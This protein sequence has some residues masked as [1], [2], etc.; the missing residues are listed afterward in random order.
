[1]FELN[2]LQNKISSFFGSNRSIKK[3]DP[4]GDSLDDQDQ[5]N[6]NEE[7]LA[8]EITAL[9]DDGTITP[10]TE[11]VHK[12]AVSK[13][14]SEEAAEDFANTVIS[15]YFSDNEEDYEDMAKE[16]LEDLEDYE[17]EE[18]DEDEEIDEDEEELDE[19]EKSALA[20]LRKLN[21]TNKMVLKGMA[22]M[23]DAL[24][25]ALDKIQKFEGE[26]S[27]LKEEISFM[28]SKMG[29]L[30]FTPANSKA[31]V[32][33]VQTSRNFAEP[34]ISI[35]VIKSWVKEKFLQGNQY[36][37]TTQEVAALDQGFISNN[38]KNN[39]LKERG[40]K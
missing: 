2:K 30:K 9:L 32:T 1:M 26:N 21:E 17:D 14:L 25:L 7:I 15:A 16:D 40:I 38:I 27:S 29:E 12:W 37:F 13:G 11:K 18:M 4:L 3:S 20:E 19:I 5:G 39:Y 22:T 31:P 28:K 24:N 33:Q 23:T 36:N 34:E 10:E 35:P 8:A 6:S